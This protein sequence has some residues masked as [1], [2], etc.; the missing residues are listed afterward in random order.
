MPELGHQ[1]ATNKT[2]VDDFFDIFAGDV[3][4]LTELRSDVDTL[5]ETRIAPENQWLEVGK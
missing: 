1:K 3:I 2:V 4:K 5:P